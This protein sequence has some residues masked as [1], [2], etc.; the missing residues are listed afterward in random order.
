MQSSLTGKLMGAVCK[1]GEED[2]KPCNLYKEKEIFTGD[3]SYMLLCKRL[4]H[5]QPN[6]EFMCPG[7][8]CTAEHLCHMGGQNLYPQS[9]NLTTEI[10]HQSNR[11]LAIGTIIHGITSKSFI[12]TDLLGDYR[13]PCCLPAVPTKC[14]QCPHDTHWGKAGAVRA[15][16]RDPCNTNKYTMTFW[17][18]H[19]DWEKMQTTYDLGWI[20][21]KD[22]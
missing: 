11:A 15:P 10:T 3:M 1:Q 2:N 12:W 14:G 20:E 7:L 16:P 21:T 17:V 4:S 22:W 19:R 13:R 5:W 6:K 9:V 18:M 8:R